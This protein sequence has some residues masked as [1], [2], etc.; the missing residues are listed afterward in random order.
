MQIKNQAS[1]KQGMTTLVERRGKNADMLMDFSALILNANQDFSD[2]S[3]QDE[4]AFLL[5]AGEAQVSWPGN[6]VRVQRASLFDEAP[7]TSPCPLWCRGRNQG[8][9]GRRRVLSHSDGEQKGI[10]PASLFS[11]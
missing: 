5:V 10:Q 3:E 6:S 8:W 4:R 9:A 2:Y 11:K 1:F 7:W